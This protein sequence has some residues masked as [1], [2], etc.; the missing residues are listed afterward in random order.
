MER[1]P[2]INVEFG[3]LFSK[4]I[5]RFGTGPKTAQYLELKL[6]DSLGLKASTYLAEISHYQKGNLLGARHH[7]TSRARM[8][9]AAS[10]ER[11]L[12]ILWALKV[13]EGSPLVEL[14][15][16]E[17]EAIQKEIGITINYPPKIDLREPEFS[18]DYAKSF[19]GTNIDIG[20][21]ALLEY[22]RVRKGASGHR[23]PI[24]GV[25]KDVNAKNIVLEPAYQLRPPYDIGGVDLPIFQSTQH[26]RIYRFIEIEMLFSGEPTDVAKSLIEH[27]NRMEVYARII[28]KMKKPYLEVQHA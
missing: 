19:D 2:Y 20:E 27:W 10:I 26:A 23:D 22:R 1:D 21:L 25:I 18:F 7:L 12:T 6:K 13:S 8:S 14:V 4:H 3:R 11:L 17:T 9:F 15:K 5:S 24:F 28:E 16:R